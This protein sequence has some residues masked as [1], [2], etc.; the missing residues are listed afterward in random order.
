MAN[1]IERE[2]RTEDGRLLFK[3]IIRGKERFLYLKEHGQKVI[4]RIPMK[5]LV[6]DGPVD[7]HIEVISTLKP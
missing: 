4:Y 2:I 1:A 7:E 6:G 3:V 5:M